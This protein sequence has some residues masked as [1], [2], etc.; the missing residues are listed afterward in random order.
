[1]SY[2]AGTSGTDMDRRRNWVQ[3]NH[4]AVPD[5]RSA[6]PPLTQKSTPN[7]HYVRNYVEVVVGK[8]GMVGVSLLQWILVKGTPLGPQKSVS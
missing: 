3:K 4:L 2:K 5:D 6:T 8:L 1:M 7:A